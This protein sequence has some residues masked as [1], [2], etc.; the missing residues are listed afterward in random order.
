[1]RALV[2]NE[3]RSYREVIAQ[4]MRRL[5][6]NVEVHETEPEELDRE[7]VRLH[8]D[9]VVCSW[10]TPTVESRVPIWVELYPSHEAHSKVSIQGHTTVVEDMQIAD[11]FAALDR[12]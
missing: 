12:V 8:P 2:A 4:A 7:I 5:R 9:F 10:A 11:L 1:M 3:L 6:P